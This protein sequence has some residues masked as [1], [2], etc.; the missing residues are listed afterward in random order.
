MSAVYIFLVATLM[1]V[2]LVAATK[3]RTDVT[4]SGISSG[5]AMATQLH[6]A[7]SK[8]ISGCGILAGPPYY[9]AGNGMTM[10][11]CMTGPS[12]YIS[13]TALQQTIKTY[14][15]TG[16]IDDPATI[17]ND[18]VY[19]FSGKLDSVVHPGTVKVNEDLYSRFGANVKTNFDMSANHCFPTESY[20]AECAVLNKK[21]YINDCDF[22]MAYEMLNH[23]YGGNLIKPTSDS[24]TLPIGQLLLF[25]QEAFMNSAS[26]VTDQNDRLAMSQWIQKNMALFNSDNWEWSNPALFDITMPSVALPTT[27][28]GGLSSGFD[29]HGFVYFPSACSNGQKCPIHVALH[30]CE[31]GRSFVGDTFATKAGYLEV[32]ELNNIIVVFPQI[33]KST[34]FPTNPMGCW[35]WWGY[36]S[37]YYPTRHAP[38]ISGIKNMIGTVRMIN[39]AFAASN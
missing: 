39:T 3:P 4:V 34:I 36:S 35:D 15:L 8:E 26:L 20:G 11:L 5:G 27:T 28:T 1:V 37:V 38:Q 7:L 12:A 19:V 17:I 16:S 6:F 18:P 32:A 25:D 22:H 24:Q 10:V 29:K 14:A 2:S 21:S 31:Q 13:T 23:I 33:L 9:C 30:G